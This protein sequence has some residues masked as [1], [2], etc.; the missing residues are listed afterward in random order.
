ML[1]R[2]DSR[3]Q[4]T[5]V[6][7]SA[8]GQELSCPLPRDQAQVVHGYTLGFLEASPIL[9]KEISAM[10]ENETRLRNGVVIGTHANSF[11]SI[12]GRTLLAAVFDE[13]STWRDE[14]SANRMKKVA[15]PV[16]SN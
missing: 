10:T 2:A 14:A 13:S 16:G 3:H 7:Q 15:D 8:F 1:V 6:W 11:W 5:R 12:H 9:R 4:K